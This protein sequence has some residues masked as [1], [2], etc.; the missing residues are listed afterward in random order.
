MRR[1]AGKGPTPIP[2][3]SGACR[4]VP[5][6]SP[7]ERPCRRLPARLNGPSRRIAAPASS[8][9]FFT[10]RHRQRRRAR[11][12]T[13]QRHRTPEHRRHDDD[14]GPPQRQTIA[15]GAGRPDSARVGGPAPRPNPGGPNCAQD[16]VAG[17]APGDLRPALV[18]R[19]IASRY[20]QGRQPRPRPASGT[21]SQHRGRT[22]LAQGC[23]RA[24]SVRRPPSRER[25]SQDAARAP[26]GR[27]SKV[28]SMAVRQAAVVESQTA[29][30][31]G[32]GPE[33]AASDPLHM[34]LTAQQVIARYGWGRTKGYQML[35]SRGFPRPVGRDRYRL[36]SLLVWESAQISEA[37]PALPS[38]PPRKRRSGTGLSQRS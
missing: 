22:C 16:V 8:T 30:G 28:T 21:P 33:G 2:R 26:A 14:G 37:K 34:F 38:L 15:S 36:D 9:G 4:W 11:D 6:S 10:S 5:A 17:S 23:E 31:H 1:A 13:S 12:G 19:P 3:Q 18:R 32:E 29:H 27:P 25:P 7:P 24:A 35:R 20:R